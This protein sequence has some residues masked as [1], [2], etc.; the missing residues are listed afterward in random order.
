[1]KQICVF[2]L[3]LMFVSCEY[4]NVKKT[5]SEA[6]LND[7]LQ[8]F[9][10]NDV[11]T[12]PTFSLCDSLVVKQEKRH[13]FEKVITT[14]IFNFLENEVIVVTQDINDTINLQFQVSEKGDLAL[15]TFEVD[16]VTIKE[17]PNI[18]TLIH[19][20]LDSLPKI[21]PAIKRRQQVKTEFELP[22]IINV[23]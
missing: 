21:F 19:K 12:Y 8:T 5:S 17:I 7:Q 23:K 20:S 9:N 10:W 2:I 1:M 14:Q 6:I 4:F 15:L 11:D 13:C 3:V 16:S 22:V 18:K